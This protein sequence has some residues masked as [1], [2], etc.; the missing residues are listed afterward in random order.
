MYFPILKP[1]SWGKRSAA[2]PQTIFS[3]FPQKS[4]KKSAQAKPVPH[5]KTPVSLLRCPP[6]SKLA[7]IFAYLKIHRYKNGHVHLL[8]SSKF[9]LS[10][11][12]DFPLS[13]KNFQYF[14]VEACRIS[15][16]SVGYSHYQQGYPQFRC[17]FPLSKFVKSCIFY[18][19]T[20][21]MQ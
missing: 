8:L 6:R 20:N 21:K 10:Y 16:Y 13:R 3:E 12:G 18:G 4:I 17:T 14:P 9:S 7:Y 5:N 11:H 2:P 15:K 1:Q 19:S